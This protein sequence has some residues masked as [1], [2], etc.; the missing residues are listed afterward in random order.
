MIQPAREN[1]KHGTTASEMDPGT[2]SEIDSADE[3]PSTRK[4]RKPS[5]DDSTLGAEILDKIK[6]WVNTCCSQFDLKLSSFQEEIVVKYFSGQEAMKNIL[7]ELKMIDLNSENGALNLDNLLSKLIA[8]MPGCSADQVMQKLSSVLTSM[9]TEEKVRGILSLMDPTNHSVTA[10]QSMY[11]HSNA[12][13]ELQNS[14]KDKVSFTTVEFGPQ[15][16]ICRCTIGNQIEDGK[17][18]SPH[19]AR[20]F[21]ILL[22]RHRLNITKS[23]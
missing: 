9:I 8:C 20:Q 6:S 16:W 21:A 3:V 14:G 10:Q 13:S 5:G 22:M 15:K 19:Q 12:E 7:F 11:D 1:E 23:A 2:D 17:G 4:K 18:T